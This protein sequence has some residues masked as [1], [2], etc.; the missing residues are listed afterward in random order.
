MF[1]AMPIASAVLLISPAAIAAD[2]EAGKE[3]ASTCAACHGENGISVAD[4]IPN[5]AGQK[6]AYL[7]AQLE[8]FRD[9]SRENASMNAIAAQLS[10]GDIAN[11]AAYYAGLSGAPSGTVTSALLPAL[12]TERVSFPENYEENFIRYDTISFED[13]G[14]VRYYWANQEA[15]DA[16]RDGGDF[17]LGSY[18][19]VEVFKAQMDGDGNPV[20]GED[21]HFVAEELAAFTAMEKQEGWGQM[22]PERLRNGDWNYAVFAPD[23]SHN[24]VNHASCLACHKPLTDTDYSFTYSA[25]KTYAEAQ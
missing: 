12:T 7:A 4:D 9:G 25:L 24:E 19:L 17:P 21:G 14:Q 23:G 1:R 8:Q 22:I 13:R 10:D 2:V 15:L 5:L 11:V 3:V 20:T 6:E 18:L 16:V